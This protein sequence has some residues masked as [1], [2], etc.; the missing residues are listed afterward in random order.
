M[1]LKPTLGTL[2]R[3]GPRAEI[4]LSTDDG[5]NEKVLFGCVF[6]LQTPM[7]IYWGRGFSYLQ[8]PRN[9]GP[10]SYHSTCRGVWPAIMQAG[11]VLVAV[12]CH[13]VLIII[14]RFF[15]FPK[16][17]NSHEVLLLHGCIFD[18]AGCVFI[19]AGSTTQGGF[20]RQPIQ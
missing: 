16:L 4:Q 1:I 18:A 6:S 8:V 9:A 13:T 7:E 12:G 2:S 3:T 17:E 10:P 20:G 19:A 15:D 11:C 5:N 14:D